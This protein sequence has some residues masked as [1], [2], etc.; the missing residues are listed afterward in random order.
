MM[1]NGRKPSCNGHLFA[2]PDLTEIAR[3]G[4]WWSVGSG[5][6]VSSCCPRRPDLSF[7]LFFYISLIFFCLFSF[8]L[9][10]LHY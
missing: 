9:S 5:G 10:F 4:L 8:F 6:A 2:L 1:E 3:F 7:L